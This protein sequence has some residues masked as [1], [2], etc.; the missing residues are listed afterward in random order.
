VKKK[1]SVLAVVRHP[2]AFVRFL[3]DKKAPLL[4]RLLALFAVLYVIMPFDAI[5]DAIP[6]IGWLDDVGVIALV[7]GWTAK[8]VAEYVPKPLQVESV[9]SNTQGR[10]VKQA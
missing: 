4:P 2:S 3:R 1:S 9:E 5:P 7:L 6:I 10:V 8:R